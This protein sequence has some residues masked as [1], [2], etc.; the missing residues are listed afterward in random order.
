MKNI[1]LTLAAIMISISLNAQIVNS[2]LEKYEKDEEIE[3]ISIGKKMLK[4]IQFDS[5]AT[6]ELKEAI[7][8]LENIKVI[9]SQGESDKKEY[10]DFADQLIK[11]NKHLKEVLFLDTPEEILQI[12]VKEIK[13]KVRELII[14]SHNK[15]NFHLI[16]LSGIIEL[17]LLANY[18][19]VMGIKGLDKLN[20]IK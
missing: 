5:I 17:E 20:N 16:T 13:G 7:S 3:V 12:V 1:L 2:F 6:P 9:Y 14:I 4:E 10:Y 15:D 18:S 19:H 8:G 11:N